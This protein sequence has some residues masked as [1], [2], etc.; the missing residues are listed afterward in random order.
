MAIGPK[1][2]QALEERGLDALVPE[3]YSSAGLERML[4]GRCGSILFLRSA[5]GS[6]YLSQ[7]LKEAGLFVDDIPVYDTVPSGDP[8]LDEM[9]MMIRSVN[10]FAFTSSSTAR[11]LVQ[12]AE[13]LGRSEELYQ[14]LAAGT[15]AAIGLPTA[16]ELEKLGIK[17]DVMPEKFTFQAM[18]A[19]LKERLNQ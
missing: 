12:R 18:L 7:G 17:V 3:E 1:T 16:Q 19:L 6:R 4:R 13:K 10:I 14:A 15:V 11:F 5:Q 2:R 8:R 9:I